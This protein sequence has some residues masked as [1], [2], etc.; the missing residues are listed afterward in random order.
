MGNPAAAE[1]LAEL[2][3]RFESHLAA[4]RDRASA[5]HEAIRAGTEALQADMPAPEPV[6]GFAE[7][8]QYVSPPNPYAEH[9]LIPDLPIMPSFDEAPPTLD[10]VE[11]F[12]AVDDDGAPLW[13]D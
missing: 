9:A 13:Q 7:P 4:L 1:H 6:G 10:A 12:A 3:A 2:A 5:A 8:S 11:S